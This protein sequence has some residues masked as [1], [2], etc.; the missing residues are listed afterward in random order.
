MR[1]FHRERNPIK[2]RRFHARQLHALQRYRRPREKKL[3]LSDV[4]RL[5]FELMRIRK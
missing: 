4:K 2:R 5:L 1:A 3:R